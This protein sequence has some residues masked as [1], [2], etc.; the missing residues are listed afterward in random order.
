VAETLDSALKERLRAVLEDDPVTEA[1]LRKLFDE[2][3]AFSLILRGFLEESERELGELSADPTSSLADIA[4]AFR[5]VNELRPDLDELQ[6]LLAQVEAHAR[7]FRAGW[8]S[9]T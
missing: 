2:G 6:A 9:P 7:E 3:H 4:A 5:R 8:L 1:D